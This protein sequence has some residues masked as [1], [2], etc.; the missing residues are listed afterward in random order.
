M[1]TKR[2]TTSDNAD[3]KKKPTVSVMLNRVFETSKVTK[4]RNIDWTK[5][6]PSNG[7]IIP[8]NSGRDFRRFIIKEEDRRTFYCTYPQF[9][10]DAKFERELL[11]VLPIRATS[12][13]AAEIEITS[14]NEIQWRDIIEERDWDKKFAELNAVTKR[15]RFVHSI[16]ASDL[17]EVAARWENEICARATLEA[18][19]SFYHGKYLAYKRMAEHYKKQEDMV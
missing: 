18:D 5:P 11:I 8:Y 9:G 7:L 16:V 4:R 1:K 12:Y 13:L 14:R 10:H 2:N 17:S 3:T 19:K 6:L 15:I